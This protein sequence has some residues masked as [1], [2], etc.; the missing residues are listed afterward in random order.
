MNKDGL[1]KSYKQYCN[2]GFSSDK[3]ED[4]IANRYYIAYG[5]NMCLERL[6]K[7]CA[8]SQYVGTG[9]LSDYKLLFRKSASGFYASI[10]KSTEGEEVPVVV[11]K[12]S[13]ADE[14][15]LDR[16]EGCPTW[17]KKEKMTVVLSDGKSVKGIVYKLP[18]DTAKIGIPSNE[19]YKII[20]DAYKRLG[21]NEKVLERAFLFSFKR[22]DPRDLIINQVK[23]KT[24]QTTLSYNFTANNVYNYNVYDTYSEKP[25]KKS[26]KIETNY[27]DVIHRDSRQLFNEIRVKLQEEVFKMFSDE[28]NLGFSFKSQSLEVMDVASMET[29]FVIYNLEDNE[30]FYIENTLMND[31]AD[32][33]NVEDAVH[34]M[35]T[36]IY[37]AYEE[38]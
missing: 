6:K 29:I 15:M 21:L 32:F 18:E 26:K 12:I 22:G 35:K 19:Y 34:Y 27:Y 36:S 24:Q 3:K 28:F 25:V 9:T 37:R 7:R 8:D 4:H 17:Y 33:D 11:F 30:C 10:D 1:L 16:Y 5:S 23:P 2:Y 20:S 31:Y 38:V 13:K 14:T